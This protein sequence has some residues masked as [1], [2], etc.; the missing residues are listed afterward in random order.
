M[1]RYWLIVFESEGIRT[2]GVFSIEVSHRVGQQLL[3]VRFQAR[4]HSGIQSARQNKQQHFLMLLNLVLTFPL[5]M[6]HLTK[7]LYPL[8]RI[9][10]FHHRPLHIPPWLLI[11][12]LLFPRLL[13]TIGLFQVPL[14]QPMSNSLSLSLQVAVILANNA[15][16][17]IQIKVPFKAMLLILAM[18]MWWPH[19]WMFQTYRRWNQPR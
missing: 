10:K 15:L 4:T 7:A 1:H 6:L 17:L 2:I 12:V 3:C 13:K 19:L 5:S 16:R 8:T 18:I 11:P 14:F 9:S